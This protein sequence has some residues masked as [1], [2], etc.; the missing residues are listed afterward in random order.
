MTAR[1]ALEPSIGPNDVLRFALELG[2]L[3]AVGWWGWT[4]DHG[5]PRIVV[6]IGLPLLVA[7]L[8]GTFRVH[9]DPGDA[10][11]AVPGPVRLALE[12]AVFGAATIALVDAVS[13][14]VGLGFGVVV[15]GHYLVARRRVIGLATDRWP[16]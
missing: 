3:A 7:V 1:P 11:V 14:A 2:A 6:A 12:A 9:G 15:V 4:A 13:P 8:W 5:G 10:P 16:P